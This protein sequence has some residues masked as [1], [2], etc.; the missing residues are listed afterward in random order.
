MIFFSNSKLTELVHDILL[1]YAPDD[2]PVGAPTLALLGLE[3]RV[4]WP[5]PLLLTE[6]VLAAYQVMFRFL[7]RLRYVQHRLNKAWAL[8]V[9]WSWEL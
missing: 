2:R 4:E 9:D 6:Q 3:C 7:L 8:Q 1:Y 5:L